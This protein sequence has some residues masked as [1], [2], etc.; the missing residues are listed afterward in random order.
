M[1]VAV[2]ASGAT[3]QC[4][5]LKYIRNH[6]CRRHCDTL[7]V[8]AIIV[9]DYSDYFRTTRGSRRDTCCSCSGTEAAG[10]SSVDS[11]DTDGNVVRQRTTVGLPYQRHHNDQ[12]HGASSIS[13]VTLCAEGSRNCGYASR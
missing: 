4:G 6:S 13:M 10:Y 2:A 3:K 1:V 7:G 8:V 9:G 5:L 11:I 12:T